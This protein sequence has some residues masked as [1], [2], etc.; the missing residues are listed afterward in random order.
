MRNINVFKLSTVILLLAIV[1]ILFRYS[2]I[3]NEFSQNGRYRLNT[4]GN[5]AAVIDTRSG[6]VYILPENKK[7]NSELPK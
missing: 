1:A 4:D 2:Q 6:V 7:I 3:L 5:T